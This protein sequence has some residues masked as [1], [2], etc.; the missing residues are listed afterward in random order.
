[1]YDFGSNAISTS[2]GAVIIE[3]KLSAPIDMTPNMAMTL[4][5]KGTGKDGDALLLSMIGGTVSGES[6]GRAD[7]FV[8]LNFEGWRDVILLDLDSAEYDTTKYSFSGIGITGMQYATYR[9]VANY[10]SMGTIYIRL[11]GSTAYTAQVGEIKAYTHTD[12]PIKNPT[13][14]VG[15]STMTFNCEM[16]GGEY[17]EYDPL[18]GKATL[19]HNHTQTKEEITFTGKLS[20]PAGAYTASYS[21]EAQTKAPLRARVVLGFS[22]QE[23]TN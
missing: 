19:Y 7:Y 14:K 1:M 8:D 16:K 18:T 13:V 6:G 4:R 17:L 10:K 3:K 21:A 5:V 11:C 22:G 20:V 12:A 23:I 2:G 15:S 9:T